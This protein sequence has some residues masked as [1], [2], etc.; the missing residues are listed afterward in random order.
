MKRLNSTS[1]TL[2]LLQRNPEK[3]GLSDLKDLISYGASPRA[4]INLNL[5]SRAIAF[6]EQRAYVTPE[7]VRVIAMD[8]LRHRVI[9]TYEA[10]AEDVQS[11]Q[12]VERILN[13]V[14]V[15]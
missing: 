12:I 11:E 13:A 3:F 5:A 9:P 8:V 15:P 1:S 7:D 14:H 2:S 10:E 6:M 4:S